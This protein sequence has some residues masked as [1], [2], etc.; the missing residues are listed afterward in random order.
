[1]DPVDTSTLLLGSCQS[2]EKTQGEEGK[3]NASTQI[4]DVVLR[5]YFAGTG[6]TKTEFCEQMGL[7]CSDFSKWLKDKQASPAPRKAVELYLLRRLQKLAPAD[8]HS[9]VPSENKRMSLSEWL[10]FE[11]ELQ[12]INS[13]SFRRM[14]EG[15]P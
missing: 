1:M 6:L 4:S 12:P 15:P 5:R 2:M 7:D 9:P 13:S 14:L 11:E 8:L 3:D 10:L